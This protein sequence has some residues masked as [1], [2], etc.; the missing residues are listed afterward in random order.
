MQLNP[1]VSIVIPVYNGSNYMREAIDSALAQTYKNIEVIVINDGSSDGGKTDEIIRSYGDRI[2]NF[3]K[4]NGGVASALNLGIRKMA[5][6][7]FSWLSHDDLYCP[8]KIERQVACLEKGKKNIV[9][10]SDYDRIDGRGNIIQTRRIKHV[11]PDKFRYAL[12]SILPINGCTALVPKI[13]FEDTG[14]FDEKLKTSQDYDMWFRMAKQYD[15]V[16]IPDVLMKSRVHEEQG[17]VMM[18][19]ISF[20][21]S[22]SYFMKCLDEI[23]SDEGDSLSS[24]AIVS[25]YSGFAISLARI[26]YIRPAEK[27]LSIAAEASDDAG[28][29]FKVKLHITKIIVYLMKIMLRVRSAVSI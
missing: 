4:E 8:D 15:F 20:D 19:S 2:C 21:E 5:G 26:G 12:I 6:D 18:R 27:A 28:I 17:T 3:V 23:F 7:Y 11:E 24:D 16:H 10:Y 25:L 13:C 14:L 9:L 22:D 1:K 29:L